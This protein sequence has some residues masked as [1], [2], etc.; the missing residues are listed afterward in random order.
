MVFCRE[1][2]EIQADKRAVRPCL[3]LLG[4]MGCWGPAP[5]RCLRSSQAATATAMASKTAAPTAGN[6]RQLAGEL[7]SRLVT[8]GGPV[9]TVPMTSRT[10][11]LTADN[12]V[13]GS[14]VQSC[15][16]PCRGLVPLQP[17]SSSQAASRPMLRQWQHRMALRFAVTTW[18][19]ASQSSG[20]KQEGSRSVVVLAGLQQTC[21]PEA[22]RVASPLRRYLPQ[23]ML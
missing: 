9:R 4:L 18:R 7:C 17:L 19:A 5:L 23:K 12:K 2:W 13:G 15:L 8:C 1:A 3:G 14:A 16:L 20:I 6:K 10:A 22:P 21:T 11:G